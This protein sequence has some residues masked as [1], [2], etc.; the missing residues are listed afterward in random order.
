ME[1]IKSVSKI[2]NVIV[3][4]NIRFV[5]VFLFVSILGCI[6]PYEFVIND[7][8]PVL[9]V[10]GFITDVS[11]NQSKE[12]PSD[13]RYFQVKLSYT[14]DVTNVRGES[15]SGATVQLL[16]SEDERWLYKEAGNGEYM[17]KYSDFAAIPG[18]SYKLS[19]SISGG[20]V[21]ESEW[22][23]LP[24]VE[25]QQMGEI[26]F[27]ETSKETYEV[28]ANEKQVITVEGISVRVNIPENVNN[29]PRYY[30]WD[31][32]PMWEYTVPL[33]P[34]VNK[35]CWIRSNTYLPNYSLKEDYVGHYANDL[36]FIET[37]GN[38][39]LFERFSLLVKQY[40]L[41][42]KEYYFFSELQELAN[43]GAFFDK[44]PY[45]LKTNISGVDNDRRVVGYFWIASEQARRWYFDIYDL[46]Y[47]VYNHLLEECL[48][49][50][51]PPAVG[52]INPCRDC[53]GYLNG[54]PSLD[55]PEWWIR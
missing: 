4:M 29:Q 32:E 38:E 2:I 3:S 55:E 40:M 1:T 41:G 17:L 25:D 37:H 10:E 13:G 35:T 53:L 51:G 14:S 34:Y 48:K 24:I 47:P 5:Y 27:I 12:Y 44:P 11:Y 16:S 21:F 19:I 9:V 28:V 20:D 30:R 33:R 8:T 49:P 23:S 46:S 22:L 45:N 36:F 39:R 7:D 6:E 52:E 31:V 43:S 50:Y 18:V 15:V 26:S 54:R 42:E